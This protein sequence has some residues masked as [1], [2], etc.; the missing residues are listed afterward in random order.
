[1]NDK[2]NITLPNPLVKKVCHKCNT[3]INDNILINDF[4]SLRCGLLIVLQPVCFLYLLDK[5]Q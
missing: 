2:I 5:S 4:Q 1:M 3:S